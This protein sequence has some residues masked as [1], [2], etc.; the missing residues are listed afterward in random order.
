MTQPQ[1]QKKS[2]LLSSAAF[3]KVNYIYIKNDFLYQF[4][5][6]SSGGC[7]ETKLNIVFKDEYYV[8]KGR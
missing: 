3:F 7:R 8:F 2:F 1:N 6:T 4:S 5:F